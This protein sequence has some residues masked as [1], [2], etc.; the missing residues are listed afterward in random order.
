LGKLKIAAVLT[1]C[2]GLKNCVSHRYTVVM[3]S[4]FRQHLFMCYCC[5]WIRVEWHGRWSCLW[6]V[7]DI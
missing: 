3:L 2:P 6:R 7:P 4:D 5:C 1:Y